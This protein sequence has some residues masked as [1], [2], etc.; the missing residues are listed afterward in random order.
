M[1]SIA[2]LMTKAVGVA[3][4]LG[5][6]AILGCSGT[7]PIGGTGGSGGGGPSGSCPSPSRPTGSY[8][9][10]WGT[11]SAF[12]GFN[13]TYPS[14]GQAMG[15]IV[16]ITGF[17]TAVSGMAEW[18]PYLASR[19]IATF[20]IDPPGGGDLPAVRSRALLAALASLRSEATRSGSPLNG[21]LDVNR[22]AIA[23]WS[24]GGGGTL[25]TA[26]QNPPG[27]KAAVAFAPWE[28][29]SYLSDRVPSLVLAGGSAD[30]LVNHSMSRNQYNSIPASTPKAYVEPRG[31]DHFQWQRPSGASGVAGQYT[32]AWLNAYVNGVSEC[33]SVIANRSFVDFATSSL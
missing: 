5:S 26:N 22:L 2:S 25:L 33:K 1:V 29:S 30:A 21:K 7:P 8:R 20:L 12:L 15:G 3:T 27:V 16:I 28:G 4:L 13:I 17:I 31:A 32:W 24:M 19:G 11:N 6:V 18:G 14:D 23:G 9:S 10:G